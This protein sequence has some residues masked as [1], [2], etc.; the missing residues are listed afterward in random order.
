MEGTVPFVNIAQK[1]FHHLVLV[2]RW[3]HL[4]WLPHGT[5]ALFMVSTCPVRVHTLVYFL[6]PGPL[7][8]TVQ[9]NLQNSFVIGSAKLAA[10]TWTPC[11]YPQHPWHTSVMVLSTRWEGWSPRHYLSLDCQFLEGK[12]SLSI[13]PGQVQPWFLIK[14]T[15]LLLLPLDSK[16]HILYSLMIQQ[17]LWEPVWR[18]RAG[19]GGESTE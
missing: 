18:G 5:Y 6:M 11:W 17:L 2:H 15:W 8:A 1:T 4:P 10:L 13:H 16:R 9:V 19:S 7:G 12:K 14:A 3:R